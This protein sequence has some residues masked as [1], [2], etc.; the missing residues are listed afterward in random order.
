MPDWRISFQDITGT[1]PWEQ[2]I[3]EK[4]IDRGR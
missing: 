3:D 4:L 1:G 2:S